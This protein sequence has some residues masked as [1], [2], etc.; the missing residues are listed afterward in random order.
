MTASLEVAPVERVVEAV[1]GLGL[2]VKVTPTGYVAQCPAHDDHDPSLS[3]NTGDDGRALLRCHAGCT[4]DDVIEALGLHWADLHS[5]ADDVDVAARP[6]PPAAPT[7]YEYRRADGTVFAAVRRYGRKRFAQVRRVGEHWE[8]GGCDELRDTPYRLDELTAAITA[9]RPVLVV[10][11]ERDVDTAW[12]RGT[13]ATC[14]AGGA[15]KWTPAHA[16]HLTGADVVVVRDQDD[17]GRRHAADVAASLH[18]IVRSVR[19]VDPA[20]GKD[21]TD[22][23]AAGYGVADLRPA[24]EHGAGRR[25]ALVRASTIRP[26]RMRWVWDGY[27]PLGELS[28]LAG[29]EGLGKSTIAVDRAARV[30]R[31]DLPGEFLGHPR[32]VI[33]VATEDSRETTIVPRLMAAS[34][35]M[36]RVLFVDVADAGLT[37]SLVLPL[38]V[39]ALADLITANDVALVVLD[40]A[41]SAIDARLNGDRDREM[42]QGLEAIKAM[43]ERT[44]CAVVGIVHFGKRDSTDTGKLILG[45]IAWSQVAR[46]VVAVARD[47]ES[48]ELVIS[49]TK[50]NLAPSDAASLGARIVEGDGRHRRRPRRGRARGVDRADRPARPRSARWAGSHRTAHRAGR[51]RGLAPRPPHRRRGQGVQVQ[52]RGHQ[53]RGP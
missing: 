23:V 41:T 48:G 10:E 51:G 39:E 21:Y 24:A 6:A 5:R 32:S 33:Y 37:S 12:S 29:R 31:G 1:E 28:L 16:A 13:P 17:P 43:A 26:R 52:V 36:D 46:S 18:N 47:N 14:N 40:P 35:D 38:D 11:G 9:G 15:G 8:S 20:A 42:R 30:T 53:A 3:I 19:V 7:T 50:A 25:L 2:L 45:S 49:A 4:V 27:V 34:A 44:R 22:H